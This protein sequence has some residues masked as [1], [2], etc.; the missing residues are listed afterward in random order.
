MAALRL[1]RFSLFLTLTLCLSGI[2]R[3]QAGGG[4]VRMTGVVSELVALS[5]PQTDG[6]PGVL[7]NTSR[8]D[9]SSLTVTLNGNT[10]GPFRSSERVERFG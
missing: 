7:V 10:R 2:S 6:A 8:S 9:D 3:A 4:S 1:R 5:I